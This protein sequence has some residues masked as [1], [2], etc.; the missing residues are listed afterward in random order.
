MRQWS[1]RAGLLA[2]LLAASACQTRYERPLKL[3]ETA[4]RAGTLPQAGP[5]TSAGETR[6]ALLSS[7]AFDVRLPARALLTYG[8]A[9]AYAG[10]GEPPGF[11]E[12]TVKAGTRVLDT[13][14]LN[15][16]AARGW[17]DVSLPLDGLARRTT[18]SFELRL[19]D[20]D[21]HTLAQPNDLLLGVGEPTL[22][23]LDLYGRSKG[24]VLISI[25]TLRRDHVGLYGYAR[26]TTPALD[27][28]AR[29]AIVAEDAVSVSSWTLPS[30]LSMLT[31]VEPGVHGGTHSGA[32]FNGRVATLPALL[33]Q[34][35]YATQ[36]VT[37]HLYV[38][39]AY[40]L[41]TG[42]EHLDFHQD[43][44]AAETVARAEALIDRLGDRPFFLFLHFYDPHWHYAPP[45]YALRLFEH[46]Y[47]GPV[48]GLWQDFKNRTRDSLT[49]ADLAH[50]LAL[51]DGEIRYTDDNL[52][53]LLAH[54]RRRGLA[55]STLVLVTSDHGEEFLDHGSWEHQKTLY[56]EVVRV[57][58]VVH[59]PGFAP[60]RESAPASLLDVAPTLLNWAQVAVPPSMQGR[61][62]LRPLETRESYGETDHT[63]DR[64]PLLFLR[65]G[66]RSWK[67]IFALDHDGTRVTSEQWYDLA[68]DPKEQANTPPRAHIADEV[69]AR[70][71]RR[72][73]E[74]RRR[75]GPSAPAILSPAQIESLRALGYIQ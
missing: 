59:A 71:L 21:G 35:G 50:L 8:L 34:A 51:Y 10:S 12:L 16:R 22:H 53:R 64:R 38:S 54:L 17:R 48:S 32:R 69:R 45:E 36:A 63:V 28:L 72:W 42:F 67:A 2:A 5:L 74:T 30:H 27:T 19:R 57:P 62:L 4:T 31:S 11:Y 6:P 58:L 44:K 20:R 60:R 43:R 7:A 39:Q 15:P 29:R 52:G 46:S 1:S 33:K 65:G 47:S 66:A 3:L 13:R 49:P 75:G 70:A 56:E 73:Q 61:S 68:S 37:S 41:D 14:M 25:D 9:L 18:L 23:D 26:P 40:G 24:L 55:E